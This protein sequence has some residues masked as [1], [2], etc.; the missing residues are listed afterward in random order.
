MAQVVE[1]LLRKWN[2]KPQTG[3]KIFEKYV[4]DKGFIFKIHKL[5]LKTQNKID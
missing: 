1:Y 3:R 4:S 2:D 5:I